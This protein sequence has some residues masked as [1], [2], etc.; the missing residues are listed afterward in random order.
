MNPTISVIDLAN[1]T[2]SVRP[3]DTRTLDIPAGFDR[4]SAVASLD[5][6]S[7]VQCA[8]TDGGLLRYAAFT[9]PLSSRARGE[10][11]LVAD[12]AFR[13]TAPHPSS[14]RLSAVSEKDATG[15]RFVALAEILAAH[16]ESPDGCI[17]GGSGEIEILRNGK[18]GT[19]YCPHALDELRRRSGFEI[20]GMPLDWVDVA[21]PDN[22]AFR[23]M[24]A[25]SMLRLAQEDELRRIYPIP[26]FV[27]PAS[28]HA[29]RS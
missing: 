10:E 23:Q 25:A 27:I 8:S 6:H 13:A 29:L 22:W 1:S 2:V 16:P 17:C 24:F 9:S 18:L 19:A 20:A 15:P 26:R 11:C 28:R 21:D 4:C 3:S 7:Q 12:G 5:F 14:Y